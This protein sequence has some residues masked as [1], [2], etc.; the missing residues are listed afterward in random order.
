MIL[1]TPASARC[2]DVKRH[3]FCRRK[4]V[5]TSRL[6]GNY[7]NWTITLLLTLDQIR[8]F[9]IARSAYNT[10]RNCGPHQLCYDG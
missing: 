8:P 2:Q 4:N 1:V 10:N 7:Y 9:R 5:K 6:V 3:V